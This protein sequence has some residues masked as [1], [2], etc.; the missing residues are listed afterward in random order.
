[1]NPEIDELAKGAWK[2]IETES[3]EENKEKV[4]QLPSPT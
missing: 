2:S 1:L 4:S 3:E